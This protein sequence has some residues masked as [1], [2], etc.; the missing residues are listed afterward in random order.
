MKGETDEKIEGIPNKQE[1]FLKM[2]SIFA[3]KLNQKQKLILS[4]YEWL[5]ER[6]LDNT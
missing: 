2:N 6:V 1:I 4:V 5:Y 3:E